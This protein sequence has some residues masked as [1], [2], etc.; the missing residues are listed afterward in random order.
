M[1]E[2]ILDIL[3]PNVLDKSF[4]NRGTEEPFRKYL[5]EEV[6]PYMDLSSET[7]FLKSGIVVSMKD[8][9]EDSVFRTCQNKYDGDFIDFAKDN[10]VSFKVAKDKREDKK[11]KKRFSNINEDFTFSPLAKTYTFFET[12]D[13]PKYNVVVDRGEIYF[14]YKDDNF[15]VIMKNQND[16]KDFLKRI[17][18]MDLPYFIKIYENNPV[19]KEYV[20]SFKYDEEFYENLLIG[21]EKPSYFD[22]EIDKQIGEITDMIN[23]I[24]TDPHFN[25]SE[26]KEINEDFDVNTIPRFDTDE[27]LKIIMNKCIAFYSEFAN[28][29]EELMENYNIKEKAEYIIEEYLYKVI[30][31]IFVAYVAQIAASVHN[32]YGLDI[33]EEFLSIEVDDII[34]KLATSLK[35]VFVYPY[36]SKELDSSD[37]YIRII[38]EAIEDKIVYYEKLV[39]STIENMLIKLGYELGESE[40]ETEEI[41]PQHP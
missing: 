41:K 7:V 9:L 19:F 33:N 14:Y 11:N 34:S 39:N 31:D 30:N 16:L 28:D 3:E 25:V 18:R 36:R 35:K 12:I 2:K 23:L 38:C 13:G 22:K 10:I 17:K 20:D 5:V 27:C 32:E 26:T 29:P 24:E 6:F 21:V 15:D 40:E 37:S 8:F 1:E 4:N